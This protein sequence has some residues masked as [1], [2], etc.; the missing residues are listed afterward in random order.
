M[1]IST[2]S[3]GSTSTTLV[4]MFRISSTSPP[5]YPAVNPMSM[6]STPAIS[7]ATVP[8]R[9]VD[10]SPCRNCANTSCPNVVVPNQNCPDGA[11]AGGP[12]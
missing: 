10:R 12:T 9:N 7:A 4:I 2:A 8:T 5:R 1:I 6:P 3:T 11:A